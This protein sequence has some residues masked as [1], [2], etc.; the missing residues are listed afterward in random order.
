MDWQDKFYLSLWNASLSIPPGYPQCIP[1]Y[2]MHTGS[3][4]IIDTEFT[5]AIYK[6]YLSTLRWIKLQR[7]Y[8]YEMI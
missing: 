1:D 8:I 2:S 6:K 5:H 7:T 3:I 4:L